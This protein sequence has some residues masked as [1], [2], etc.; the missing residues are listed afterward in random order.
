MPGVFARNLQGW[1]FA[2]LL[3]GEFSSLSA[4]DFR[5]VDIKPSSTTGKSGFVRLE[6]Q[7]TGVVFTNVVPAE[8]HYTNQILLNGS[9]VAAGDVDGDGWCDLF[10]CG[11]G[12]GSKLYRN[13]GNWNFRDVTVESGVAAG[14]GP[15]TKLDATGVAIADLDGDTDLDLLVNSVGQGT[16]CFLNDGKGR[17]LAHSSKEYLDFRSSYLK[18]L[19]SRA[20]VIRAMDKF[21]EQ[22]WPNLLQPTLFNLDEFTRVLE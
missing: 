3:L 17:F 21:A 10:F 11:L 7:K 18:P 8:R 13:Q 22:T 4:A 16:F 9:G 19:R 14:A 5:F 12:G 6:P 1:T 15:D 20:D 2:S